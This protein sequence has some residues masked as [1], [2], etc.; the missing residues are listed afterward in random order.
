MEKNLIENAKL[1]PLKTETAHAMPP[2]RCNTS[3]NISESP[4]LWAIRI[5]FKFMCH[6]P[7]CSADECTR[8]HFANKTCFC[9]WSALC[10]CCRLNITFMFNVHVLRLCPNAWNVIIYQ[11][12][13]M[14]PQKQQ[15]GALLFF[16]QNGLKKTVACASN[17]QLCDSIAA[18]I[19]LFQWP[20]IPSLQN[21]HQSTV[22]KQ[23]NGIK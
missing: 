14:V 6:W 16:E 7:L 19:C 12:Q 22:A 15:S 13:W 5:E 23:S 4:E 10:L 20:I 9:R 18:L 17:V 21:Q 11:S 8:M 2:A 1:Y 3:S